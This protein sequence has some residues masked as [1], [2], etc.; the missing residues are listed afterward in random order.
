[1]EKLAAKGNLPSV[2]TFNKTVPDVINAIDEHWYILSIYKNF[3]P[4]INHL[5]HLILIITFIHNNYT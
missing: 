2:V 4:V 3:Y 1:M 5:L